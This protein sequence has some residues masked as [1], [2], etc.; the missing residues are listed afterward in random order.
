MVAGATTDAGS[1]LAALLLFGLLGLIGQGIRAVVGLKNAGALN[2]NTPANQSVFSA[3]YLLLS[4]MIGFIA[5]VL[6]GIALKFQD[7][8]KI[9]QSSWQ[10]LLGIIASGYV[11]ADFVEN[12]M[13][14]VIPGAQPGQNSAP[15]GSPPKAAA[16]TSTAAD[17]SQLKAQMSG[18]TS[19][20]GQ[21][22]ATLPPPPAPAAAVKV[23]AI[24]IARKLGADTQ[25][26]SLDWLHQKGID[27]V[28]RYISSGDQAKCIDAR[29]M[30]ELIGAGITVGI[31]YELTGGSP[32][33]G[34]LPGSIDSTHGASDGAYALQ[35]LKS[36]G[37]PP[38]SVVYFAVDTDVDNN[39]DINTYV[40]PYFTAAKQTLG[41][42]YRIGVYGCGSTCAAALNSAGCDKAWLANATGWNGYSKFLASGRASIIQGRATDGYDP[43]TIVESDWGGF[44]TLAVAE[45]A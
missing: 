35:T 30:A 24:D 19:Q 41:G 5:G 20:L 11:G 45:V 13:N 16:A 40:I 39:T 12:T 26:Y 22:Q 4:L 42:Y 2:A 38:G 32:K 9:D 7:L 23:S 37:V 21:I 6:A 31:V 29:E 17:L 34:G 14:L 10:Q 15:G 8:T 36:L 33:F 28:L 18:L 25:S 44:T 27:A 43:D 1:V 3:A